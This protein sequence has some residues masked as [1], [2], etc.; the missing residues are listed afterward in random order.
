LIWE[1]LK[2]FPMLKN[3]QMNVGIDLTQL[4]LYNYIEYF[5]V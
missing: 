5:V 1:Y 4:N 3:M 2:V